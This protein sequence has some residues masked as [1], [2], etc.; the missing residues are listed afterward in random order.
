M[1][2]IKAFSDIRFQKIQQQTLDAKRSFTNRI[3]SFFFQL[4]LNIFLNLRFTAQFRRKGFDMLFKI[5]AVALN[6]CQFSRK[7]SRSHSLSLSLSLSISFSPSPSLSLY[8]SLSLSFSLPLPPP[9]SLSLSL[10]LLLTLIF[11]SFIH[12]AKTEND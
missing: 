9:P 7:S 12:V 2:D 1:C 5:I 11:H 6:N 8:L 10:S 3:F 4:Y